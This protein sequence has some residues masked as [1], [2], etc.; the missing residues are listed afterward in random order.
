MKIFCAKEG[1]Q[2]KLKFAYDEK[3]VQII[4]NIKGREYNPDDRT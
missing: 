3:I 4:R 1:D 2:L